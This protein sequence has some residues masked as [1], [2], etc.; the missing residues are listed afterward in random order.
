M[1][2][3]QKLYSWQKKF[4][5][6]VKDKDSY[7]IFLDMGLGKTPISLALAE[8]NICTKVIV[9]SINSKVIESQFI[10]GSWLWWANQSLIPYN[11][12]KK[13][14]TTFDNASA[15]LLLIN[16]ESLY[17]RQKKTNSIRQAAKTEVRDNIV[18]F[19]KSC[20][21]HNVAIIIDESH[22][23]KDLHSKQTEAIIKIQKMLKS[24]A[25]RV[26]T[27]LLTGTPFTTGYIDL[28]TQLKILGH[29]GTK[30]QFIDDFCERG[31]IPGLLGW[32]QPIVSYKN[33]DKMYDLVHKFAITIKS[34]DVVKLPEKVFINHSLPISTAFKMFTEEKVVG[35][36]I[37]DY[38]SERNIS[39]SAADTLK[40]FDVD[41][42]VN[43][44]FFRNIAHPDLKWLAETTGTFWLRARQL[45]IG[46]QGSS[47]EAV[48]YDRSRLE[49]VEKF[50]QENEDNYLIFYNY[51]P[52]LL[53]L[54]EICDKLGYNIDVYC[55]EVKSL[56]FYEKHC[57]LS[58]GQKLTNKKNVI[59][60]NFA[61]GSTG[62][63][64]Q[65]YNKCIIFSTPLFKDYEQGI[66]RIHR[67]GQTKTTIYHLFYQQ[68]W[69]DSSM[70]KALQSAIQYSSD[71]FMSDLNR[72]NSMLS[73][74]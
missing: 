10:D 17:K 26:F 15:E 62:M 9:I 8:E 32:Q 44:P 13:H 37:W 42:K 11:F 3:Y 68:N 73:K 61:S 45:S 38:M 12:L 31:Q 4:V 56:T 63:N 27:Y 36:K 1:S 2:I 48:W 58:E 51:T 59:L 46:F 52:E 30:G 64:W 50:L 70:Q 5:D 67:T 19:I 6:S 66:K 33:L 28:Y 14:E 23:T 40:Y 65:Q 34:E 25:T 72:V 35:G 7:G 41:K 71:M 60:A 49:Q 39:P 55:G 21:H 18:D 22:K 57:S 29:T 74:S 24:V 20:K 16:Y 53:E 47:S 43:N 69:L 54:Y